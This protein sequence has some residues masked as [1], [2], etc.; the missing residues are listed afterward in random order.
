[1]SYA[2]VSGLL[3]SF[4]LFP[5][6]RGRHLRNDCSS[7]LLGA[8]RL[9]APFGN[10]SSSLP[11]MFAQRQ[12]RKE[13]RRK[14]A[15]SSGAAVATSRPLRAEFEEFLLV[16]SRRSWLMTN[17][18]HLQVSVGWFM[19]LVHRWRGAHYHSGQSKA[20]IFGCRCS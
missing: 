4:P 8:F 2:T 18:Q 1:M 9:R 5:P 15:P 11:I 19:P 13:R 6:L 3:T 10:R 20:N 12:L 7:E 17:A 14:R 16:R